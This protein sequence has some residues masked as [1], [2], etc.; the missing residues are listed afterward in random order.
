MKKVF[1][2]FCIA[3]FS[4]ICANAE[5]L[6]Y[7]RHSISIGA[8]PTTFD[9]L[10]PKYLEAMTKKNGNLSSEGYKKVKNNI[11]GSYSIAYHYEFLYWLHIGAKLNY[12]GYGSSW[13]HE[14]EN[15]YITG[16]YDV[17]RKHFITPMI[18]FQFNY[19]D[20]DI[21]RLYSGI[22]LGASVFIMKESFYDEKSQAKITYDEHGNETTTYKMGKVVRTNTVKTAIFAFN[23]TAIGLT[24][25]RRVYGFAE[26]NVGMD[27]IFKA[28]FGVHF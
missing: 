13:G 17:Q 27:A 24:V 1:I 21:L 15:G 11:Y 10:V 19:I 8:G 22:D 14:D 20:A 9:A 6:D 18:S 28:G 26:I 4:F 2:A 12:H 25:G 23:V 5:T 16:I 7:G 3:L